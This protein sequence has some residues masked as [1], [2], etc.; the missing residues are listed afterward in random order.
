MVQR[1]FLINP[2][3]AA[4]AWRNFTIDLTRLHVGHFHPDWLPYV[5]DDHAVCCDMLVKRNA[6]N[7]NALS[8][9]DFSPEQLL[10]L[11]NTNGADFYPWC[12]PNMETIDWNGASDSTWIIKS[13]G[14]ATKSRFILPQVKR[15]IPN[16]SLTSIQG[17]NAVTIT[18]AVSVMVDGMQTCPCARASRTKRGLGVS[19]GDAGPTTAEVCDSIAEDDL[20]NFYA[21]SVNHVLNVCWI[22]NDAFAGNKQ[23]DVAAGD[24]EAVGELAIKIFAEVMEM[25]LTAHQFPRAIVTVGANV[26]TWSVDRRFDF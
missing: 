13:A 1:E 19:Q 22:L 17:G 5:Q 9:W 18:E 23:K 2:D 12:L 10:F 20:G 15:K 26:D 16:A 4:K 25:G 8:G 11:R 14:G 3:M 7:T 21:C 6:R 24:H